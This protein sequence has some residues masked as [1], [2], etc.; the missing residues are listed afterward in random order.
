[1]FKDTRCNDMKEVGLIVLEAAHSI[2][3]E[4]YD[5]AKI[6]LKKAAS[7]DVE[8]PMVYN[9]LGIIYEKNKD[10]S[11]AAKYYRVAYYMDQGFKAASDNLDRLNDMYY[12][13][14]GEV[15]WG[16]EKIGEN[17]R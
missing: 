10:F 1:M 2:Q 16:L 8:N 6:L 14:Y 4:D 9:L 12:K 11:N 3:A 15:S 13:G 5:T 7:Y 17:L